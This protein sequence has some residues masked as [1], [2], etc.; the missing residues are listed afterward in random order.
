MNVTALPHKLPD[1]PNQPLKAS[2]GT[3]TLVLAE[4]LTD[5]A[6][7]WRIHNCKISEKTVTQAR[8]MLF[9]YHYDRLDDSI[10]QAHPLTPDLLAQFNTP[11]M[12]EDAAK[13][14]G[15]DSALLS[16][17]WQVKITGS[18]VVFSEA[19][20]LAVR[21]RWTNTGK[22]SQPIYTKEAADAVSCALKDWQFFGRVDVLYKHNAQ[23]LIS[24]D[25]Q[26]TD[27]RAAE[28]THDV[29]A[30][31]DEQRSNHDSVLKIET[32]RDYQLLPATHALTVIAAVEADKHKLPWFKDAIQD[33]LE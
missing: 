6:V 5:T 29:A 17:P 30:D 11:M 31:N 23:T 7:S 26:A 27:K 4:A 1:T 21:L 19:L 18:L 20:Q 25:E 16:N 24:I 10:K 15:I 22:P 3:D 28:D 9:L 33:R 12:A 13:L 32:S 14:I 2:L 8:P